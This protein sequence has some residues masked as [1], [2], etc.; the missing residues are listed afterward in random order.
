M[1][2]RFGLPITCLHSLG[3]N[4]SSILFTSDKLAVAVIATTGTSGNN[5]QRLPSLP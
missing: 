1:L 4:D 2:G 3:P 5:E